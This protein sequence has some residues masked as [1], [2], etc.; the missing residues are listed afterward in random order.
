MQY[1][2]AQIST[3]I[4]WATATIIIIF[5]LGIS[6]YFSSFAN[7]F[8][9]DFKISLEDEVFVTKSVSGYFLDSCE[10]KRIFEIIKDEAN[11]KDCEGEKAVRIFNN[12]F[13]KG[14]VSSLLSEKNFCMGVSKSSDSFF[15]LLTSRTIGS[16]YFGVCYGEGGRFHFEPFYL[17]E[18]HYFYVLGGIRDEK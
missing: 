18:G 17:K 16:D 14:V 10:D 12:L 2:K 3:G 7:F 13:V 11:I 6:I 1:K 15:N 8:P 5:I 4:S 9:R